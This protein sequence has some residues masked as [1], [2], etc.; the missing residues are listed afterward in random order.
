MQDDLGGWIRRRQQLGTAQ[1]KK[2]AQEEFESS[3]LLH[4]FLQD[5]WKLQQ[6]AQLLVHTHKL[7]PIHIT[8]PLTTF[9]DAPARLKKELN[10]VL[11]LQGNID[12]IE[13]T[14]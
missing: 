11:T 13:K 14:L 1:Q 6:A 4:R 8:H 3:G 7:P 12:T 10:M 5:K 9:T 2:K